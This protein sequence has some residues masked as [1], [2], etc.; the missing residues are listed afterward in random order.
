MFCIHN[1]WLSDVNGGVLPD[2]SGGAG[3]IFSVTRTR[4]KLTNRCCLDLS[5]SRRRGCCLATA[6]QA[7]PETLSIGDD[8]IEVRPKPLQTKTPYRLRL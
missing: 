5:I 8:A 2:L 1:L 4:P 3:E 7:T 6:I